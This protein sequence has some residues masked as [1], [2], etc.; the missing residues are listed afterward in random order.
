MSD[1]RCGPPTDC[2]PTVGVCDLCC[3]R[4]KACCGDHQTVETIAAEKKVAWDSAWQ[5]HQA[6]GQPF[7]APRDCT[8]NELWLLSN[9]QAG[10]EVAREKVAEW[11][12]MAHYAADCCVTIYPCI[13]GNK[14]VCKCVGPC[15]E[16]HLDLTCLMDCFGPE[17]VKAATVTVGETSHNVDVG[18]R[19]GAPFRIDRVKRRW[20]LVGDLPVADCCAPAGEWSVTFELKDTTAAYKS[21]VAALACGEIPCPPTSK[22]C[23]RDPE[24]SSESNDGRS[25]SYVPRSQRRQVGLFGVDEVDDLKSE[26]CRVAYGFPDL[27]Q[28]HSVVWHRCEAV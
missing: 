24:T 9:A 4:G 17:R 15:D 23:G 11:V 27:G 6:S 2:Y 20:R 8:P 25:F 3:T 13:P 28:V 12:C 21:A 5:T 1:C 10:I 22:G 19:T 18:L 26:C 14:C 7:E 16:D